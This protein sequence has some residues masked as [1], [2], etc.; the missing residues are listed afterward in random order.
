[1][2][3][4]REIGGVQSSLLLMTIGDRKKPSPPE[5]GGDGGILR[6]T[7]AKHQ[8]ATGFGGVGRII[9]RPFFLLVET[10]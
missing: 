1:M 3:F 5:A 7:D 6:L 8:A 9:G 10:K 2:R 4:N